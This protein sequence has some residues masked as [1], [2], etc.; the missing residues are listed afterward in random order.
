M[1]RFLGMCSG[2]LVVVLMGIGVWGV[3]EAYGL[4]RQ[5]SLFKGRSIERASN[6]NPV[7]TDGDYTVLEDMTVMGNVIIDDTGYGVDSDVDGDFIAIYTYTLPTTGTLGMS[8]DGGFSYTPPVDWFGVV[9]YTYMISDGNVINV[10]SGGFG[11][12]AF[13]LF[14][15][16]SSYRVEL[17]DVDGD[18][19]LDAVVANYSAAREV[20]LNDGTGYLGTA[21][22]DYFGSGRGISLALGDLDGDGDLDAVI[23]N[24]SNELEQVWLNNGSGNFGSGAVDTFGGKDTV[25][26][27]LGDVDGD[28]DL[29]AVLAH[30]GFNDAEVWLNNG[31]GNFGAAAFDTFGNGSNFAVALGDLDGDGDLDAVLGRRNGNSNEVWLND[32]SGN[33]GESASAILSGGDSMDVTL[34]DLD[35]DG[36]LDVVVANSGQAQQVW[37]NDGLGNF[38]SGGAFGGNF[39]FGVALGDVDGDGDLDAGVVHFNNHVHEIWLNNGQGNFGGSAFDMFGGGNSTGLALGDMDGDGDLDMVV[40][41]TN[42]EAQEVWLNEDR[43]VAVTSEAAVVTVTVTAVNDPPIASNDVYSTTAGSQLVIPVEEGVLTN[44]TELIENDPFV[45]ILDT[46]VMTGELDLR[47][48]GAFTYTAPVSYTGVVSFSYYANDG[49]HSN[50]AVVTLNVICGVP[51]FGLVTPNQNGNDLM[52]S[53]DS[54]AGT[55]TYDI[56]SSSSNPYF[57]LGVGGDN[58]LLQTVAAPMTTWSH[59]NVIGDGMN[60]YYQLVAVSGCGAEAGLSERVGIF[61]YEVVIG[62]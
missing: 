12:T 46:D 10:G 59:N 41:H 16:G 37:K 2:L 56:W 45:A 17:G 39:S 38:V 4:E 3:A 47:V 57:N 42:N 29:D 13:Q 61:D 14:G 52:I 22:F 11:D 58:S 7:A 54:V 34:G 19:D 24:R 60:Y 50:L 6:N 40:T 36:D 8:G 1:K 35:G 55:V 43:W 28:G 20:W 25:D 62:E 44:D 32:G 33:F 27:A 23:V 9:T 53:W 51:A 18:G 21:P 31:S 15:G 48:D 5:N 26:V 30:D 49:D